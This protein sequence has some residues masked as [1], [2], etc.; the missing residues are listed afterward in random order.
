MNDRP[1]RMAAGD[2]RPAT[3]DGMLLTVDGGQGV[4]RIE[5]RG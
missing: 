3:A 4:V 2:D 5:A 1:V